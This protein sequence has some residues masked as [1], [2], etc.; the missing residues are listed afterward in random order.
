MNANYVFVVAIGTGVVAGLR[1][2]TP[3][4]VVSWAA[5][6][7]WLNLQGSPLAFN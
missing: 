3:P 6:P 7:G 5:H 1:A 2:L 4:A